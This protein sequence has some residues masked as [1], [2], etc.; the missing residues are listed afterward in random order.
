MSKKGSL[1]YQALERM[2]EL[3]R[4]GESRHEAKQKGDTSG[5]Y[6]FKTYETYTKEV[7]EFV[8]WAKERGC[9]TLEE[10]RP[11]VGEY[12][13]SHIERGDSAWSIK[14]EACALGK[15]YGCRSTD[16]GVEL[17]RRDR[18]EIERSR[19]EK[20]HDK[21]FSKERNRDLI[22][23]ARAT[24][25]RRRELERVSSRDV[26]RGPDN[27]LYVHVSNGKGGRERDV[28]VLEKYE[29]EVE[30]IVKEREDRDRLFDRVPVRM[31]VHGY[32]REY[33]EE[34]YRELSRQIEREGRE[35]VIE[36]V[37]EHFERAL[38]YNVKEKDREKMRDRFNRELEKGEGRYTRT[39]GREFDRVCLLGVSQDLGHNR[40]EVVARHYLD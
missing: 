28:H 15:L 32:R 8:E 26:F 10:A 23:F 39:D 21:E 6:S 30:R 2:R 35:I 17:P 1:K 25:L 22:L 11:L 7:M 36:R 19:G 38:E 29:K 3:I 18:G 34:R 16:F 40:V 31:D 27:R 20:E 37:R 33:A 5:I 12:L 14:A 13:S 24:G 4:F 9:R